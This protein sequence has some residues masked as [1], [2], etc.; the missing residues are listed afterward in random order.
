L[1]SVAIITKK[2]KKKEK[3]IDIVHLYAS[4]FFI[5]MMIIDLTLVHKMIYTL[6]FVAVVRLGRLYN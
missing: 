2:Q 1:A 6:R 3:Y 5:A 4:I